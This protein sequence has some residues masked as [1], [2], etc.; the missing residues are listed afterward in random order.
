M[1]R[2]RERKQR[3][4]QTDTE[5]DNYRAGER[6]RQSEPEVSRQ[7]WAKGT[8]LVTTKEKWAFPLER[9]ARW[10][11]SKKPISKTVSFNPSTKT[12]WSS[13][14]KLWMLP[15]PNA[16]LYC[17]V[18]WFLSSSKYIQ[19]FCLLEIIPSP[20]FCGLIFPALLI[21]LYL[22]DCFF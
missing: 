22:V 4:L 16:T 12:D 21:F 11:P 13:C 14:S 17:Y 2:G 3:F 6:Q 1:Q 8:V 15:N 19:S 5:W 20:S 18:S 9:I 7:M 10:Y